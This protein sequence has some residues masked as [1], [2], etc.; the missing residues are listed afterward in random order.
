MGRENI[1]KYSLPYALLKPVLGLWHSKIFY[2]RIIVLGRENFDQNDHLIFAPNHQNALMDALAVL[3]SLKGQPVFLARADIFKNRFFSSLLYFLKILPVYRIRDGYNSLKN[4]DW[5]FDKTVEVLKNKNGLVILPEGNHEGKRRLRQLKKGIC[6]IAFQAGEAS[7]F[8]M[9]IKIIPVGIEFSHY[10]RIR[11]VLTVVFGKPIEVSEYKS[12]YHQ[13]QV[14]AINSLKN[15]LSEEMRKLMVHIDSLDDYEAIDELRVIVNGRYSDDIKNPKLFRDRLLIE[16]INGLAER[17]PETYRK[18][19]NLSL[20]AGKLAHKLRIDYR[21]L[22]KERYSAARIIRD[23]IALAVTLP[24]FIYGVLLNF[25][26]YIIPELF[27]RNIKDKQFYSTII[28]SVSLGLALLIMP[29]YLVISLIVIKPWWLAL[30]VFATIP[31][32]GI[33][34]W[35]YRLFYNQLKGI[36]R[37]N[38]YLKR[39]NSDF[40]KLTEAYREI[41]DIVRNL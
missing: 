13:N 12:L 14:L 21:L 17:S 19:C 37:I 22:E 40:I 29:V 7:D 18:L 30:L 5:I 20:K 32:S 34:A 3:F 9:N 11:Q 24:L 36:I 31:V 1:E 27:T 33:F 8:S 6:R 26:F 23:L 10:Y 16:K 41:L 2:R 25:I 39:K 28:Y 38:R 4:N 35:G 15:R